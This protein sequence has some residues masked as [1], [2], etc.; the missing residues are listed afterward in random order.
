MI[1]ASKATMDVIKHFP[2]KEKV[3]ALQV[4]G[5]EIKDKAGIAIDSVL[6]AT[7]LYLVETD[8]S[9]EIE[10]YMKWMQDKLDH[11]ADWYDEAIAEGL[12]NQLHEYGIEYCR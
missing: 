8:R 6:I 1:K 12:K 5:T 11:D 2:S 10:A 3:L 9:D 7:C 4:L